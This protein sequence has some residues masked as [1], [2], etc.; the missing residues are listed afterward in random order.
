[1]TDKLKQKYL[2]QLDQDA[3]KLSNNSFLKGRNAGD[4]SDIDIIKVNS[5]DVLELASKLSDPDSSA[6][7]SD[8]QLANKKYVDDSVAAITIPSVFELQ[9]NWDASTNTPTLDNTD[10]GV[11]DYLY[12]VNVAGSVDF[13]AGSETFAVGDWVYN[14]N[15]AW[16]KADNNDDVLSVNGET[17]A[18]VLDSDDISEGSTNLYYTEGRFD[19]SLSGKDTSDIS[20]NA[21][22]LYFTDARAKTAAVVN[23]TAGSETDQ[24]PSVSA[25]KAYVDA[26]AGSTPF[27]ESVVLTSG[28]ISSGVTL[29]NTPLSGSMRLK[30]DGSLEQNEGV[31]YSVSGTT[32]T[33]LGAFQSQLEV[34]ETIYLQYEY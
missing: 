3:I 4:S 34:G 1:M 16:E 6:P 30:A 29:S 27:K 5:S 18:V 24:A 31:Q 25:I 32:L 2:E 19:T 11:A 15:G 20:E 8:A 9:G 14:V 7:T 21:S 10:S 17:G 12:Y 23:S 33:F 26:S 22:F 13:G 28:Q